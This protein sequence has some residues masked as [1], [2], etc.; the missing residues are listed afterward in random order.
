M[1]SF[2]IFTRLRERIFF[3][4][5]FIADF[6]KYS[7]KRVGKR[8]SRERSRPLVRAG[9]SEKKM[10]F[11][12]QT[13]LRKKRGGVGAFLL[14]ILAG[15]VVVA[16]CWYASSLKGSKERTDD[17]FA[18]QVDGDKAQACHREFLALEAKFN[19]AHEIKREKIA[20]EDIDVYEQ[21][22]AAYEKYLAYSG[23]DVRSNLRLDKMRRKLHTL[24][25]DKIRERTLKLEAEAERLAE[26]KSYAAAEKLFREAAEQERRIETQYALAEKRSHARTVGL[27]NRMLAMQAIPMEARAAALEK[28]GTDALEKQDW[29]AANRDLREALKLRNRLWSDYRAVS[30]SDSQSIARL[31]QLVETVDSSADFEKTE[32]FRK[33]A[34][35]A[36]ARKDWKAAAEAWEKTWRT[37]QLLEKNFPRS[38]F[39]SA[40]RRREIEAARAN[41]E[42]RPDFAE[43]QENDAALRE[44]IRERGTDRVQLLARSNAVIA[45]RI[46]EK[47]PQSTLITPE[48][49]TRLAYLNVKSRDLPQIQKAV[50]DA[51][52]PIP[53]V[54]AEARRMLRTEVSQALYTF[55]MDENP[56]ADAAEPLAPVESVSF[57]DA[58]A[59]CA[60]LA[61]LLGRA[62]RLPTIEEFLAAAG[63]F[64]E[65]TIEEHAWT[66]ENSDARIHR[67]GTRAP[68]AA[69]FCDLYGNVSEWISATDDDGVSATAVGGD[70]QFPT[71]LLA[72]EHVQKSLRKEK[73]RLRGFR[74]VVEE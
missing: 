74:V 22:V 31:N 3:D 27:H 10:H 14:M 39:A 57:E 28:S 9:S 30:A 4:F 64:D 65:A 34:L 24:R 17:S 62:V 13:F 6:Y 68:N 33:E 60:R 61:V 37:Q 47:F 12:N 11:R 15:A 8:L 43:F 67:C 44:A 29:R 25:G 45:A 49:R 5:A 16:A 23:I 38:R 69:G 2:R 72:A 46:A 50:F 54:P 73:S 70:C 59:F 66:L 53:G 55:V 41:T 21:A 26:K 48:M 51:L 36:E 63:T 35:D 1:E 7:T 52:L 19:S 56:S 18:L 20:P 40:E 32:N 42:A 71:K 58:E